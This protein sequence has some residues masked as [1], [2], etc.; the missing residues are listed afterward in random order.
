M[1]GL[2]IKK[3]KIKIRSKSVL[4]IAGAVKLIT[5]FPTLGTTALVV[6]GTK[7][8]EKGVNKKIDR[9]NKLSIE[10]KAKLELEKRAK[11][12]FAIGP[13]SPPRKE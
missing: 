10:R 12:A 5:A 6:S 11:S 3:I 7:A 4:K 1:G 8:V 9:L 13:L 2:K